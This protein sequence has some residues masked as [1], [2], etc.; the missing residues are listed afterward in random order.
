MRENH[1][2]DALKIHQVGGGVNEL[3]KKTAFF[4]LGS[5]LH[6]PHTSPAAPIP[7]RY[8]IH[9]AYKLPEMA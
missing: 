3:D 6:T 8:T 2:N 4:A 9:I 1:N 5:R 7:I